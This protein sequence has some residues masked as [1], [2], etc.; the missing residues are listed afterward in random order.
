LHFTL[1]HLTSLLP[2]LTLSGLFFSPLSFPVLFFVST[3]SKWCI[4]KDCIRICAPE[5]KT[6]FP[7]K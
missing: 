5:S 2:L 4:K 3:N 7:G 1:L 6:P